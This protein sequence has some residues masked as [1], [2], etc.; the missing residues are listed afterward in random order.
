ME[1]MTGLMAELI[2]THAK[3]TATIKILKEHIKELDTKIE[4]IKDTNYIL[5]RN[6]LKGKRNAY[7]AVVEM[8][9]EILK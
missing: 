2:A 5:T 6:Y 3:I 4:T 1:G 7:S 8:L 9:G